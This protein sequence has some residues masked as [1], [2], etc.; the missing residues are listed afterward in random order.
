MLCQSLN[1]LSCVAHHRDNSGLHE[2]YGPFANFLVFCR[3]EAHRVQY[4]PG[5]F[6]GS[7]NQLFFLVLGQEKLQP[8][9]YL[10]ARFG[11][12]NMTA[13]RSPQTLHPQ[14]FCLPCSAQK[15]GSSL[16]LDKV[17]YL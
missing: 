17:Q 12:S 8:T 5:I 7:N 13:I 16:W 14:E 9:H 4:L 2:F 11:R 10:R 1:Y 15:M 6:D 3:L